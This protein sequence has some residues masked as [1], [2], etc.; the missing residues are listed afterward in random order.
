[1]P[2]PRKDWTGQEFWW[3]TAQKSMGYMNGNNS[4]VWQW[5]CKCG[6]FVYASG[7]TVKRGYN[8]SC[9]CRPRESKK[10]LVGQRFGKLL[11]LEWTGVRDKSKRGYVYYSCLCDC[12]KTK[13][14]SS[15]CLRSGSTNSC[16]CLRVEAN[17]KKRK[18]ITGL[19]SGMLVALEPMLKRN[20]SGSIAW[21]WKCQCDCGCVSVVPINYITHGHVK[22]CGCSHPGKVIDKTGQRFGRLIVLSMVK[23]LHKH[24]FCKCLCDCGNIITI[25]SGKLRNGGTRSCGCLVEAAR[26][27]V[28]TNIDPMDVPFAVTDVMKARRELRKAIKQ[29]S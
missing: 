20:N 3:L 26:F 24:S 29:A 7:S 1:M 21:K 28:W 13:L 22:S 11:V 18:D 19:R 16:G 5:L 17:A 14:V 8:K 12:G 4:I 10:S 2:R 23:E 25:A 27:T 15:A 6:N 9:G